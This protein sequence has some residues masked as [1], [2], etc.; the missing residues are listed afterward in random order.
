MLPKKTARAAGLAMLLAAVPAAAQTT[1]E[2]PPPAGASRVAL[3]LANPLRASRF[4]VDLAFTVPGKTIGSDGFSARLGFAVVPRWAFVDTATDWAWAGARVGWGVEL[5]NSDTTAGLGRVRVE[6]VEVQAAYSRTVARTPGG[7]ALLLGPRVAVAL[8]AS[9]ESRAA[10]VY[11]HTSLGAGVDLH[12]PLG[13]GPWLSGALISVS[14]AWQHAL[15]THASSVGGPPLMLDLTAP[16]PSGVGLLDQSRFFAGGDPP[17]RGKGSLVAAAW[18]HLFHDLSLGS[19]WG[20]AQGEPVTYQLGCSPGIA[21]GAPETRWPQPMTIFDVALGYAIADLVWVAVGYDNTRV[22]EGQPG[23]NG[24][25]HSA[26][27]RA[28]FQISLLGDGVFAAASR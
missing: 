18:I 23:T 28:Y 3:G 6:D 8:P 26:D 25:F 27:A 2:A 15:G 11:V 10:G 12:L 14:G 1:A 21:C 22:T 5:A 19:A 20:F 16:R 13:R 4:D 24:F 9:T 7:L 17:G